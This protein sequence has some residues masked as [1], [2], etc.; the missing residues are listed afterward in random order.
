[1]PIILAAVTALSNEL[2][3]QARKVGVK[4]CVTKTPDMAALC[5]AIRD[6][7]KG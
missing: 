5:E 1:M 6:M 2:E 3:E 4:K 7:V